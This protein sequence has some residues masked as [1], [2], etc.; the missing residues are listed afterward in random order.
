MLGGSGFIGRY[1]VQ[2]LAA[3]GD[4]IPVGCRRAEEAKFLKPLGDVGQIA[5]LNLTIGDDQIM[6]AFLAGNDALVNCVGILRESG[7]QTFDRVHHTGPA[8]L[9]RLAREA[10]IERFVH[11]SAIGADPRSSSAYARTKAA[12][13]AAVRDAFPTVTILRPSVVF[14]AEDQFFNRFAAMATISPV[15]PL[16]G[17]G[18]TR[19]QPV[20]VGDV[21]DAVLRCLDDPTTAGRTYELGGPKVYTFRELIELMLGEIRRKRLLVDLPFGLAAI[22]ARLMSILPN[23]PLTPD[24]VELLK[25]D[26]V[27]SSGAL[28]LAALGI[29]PTAVEGV[30]P[31]YLDRFRRGGWYERRS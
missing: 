14:G 17:G 6:P 1:I 30:L 7:S 21:A 10:G 19:F 9:A 26:N 11:I 4:V 16:I 12:G 25:R 24:Q 22:Q 13:E 31:S 27:V 5:T 28:T 29:T 15:L 3:R 20:Y 8:R 23:P 18:H 2:R